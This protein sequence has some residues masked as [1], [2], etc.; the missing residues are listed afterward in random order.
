LI[1]PREVWVVVGASLAL[2]L[3]AAVMLN[4]LC[5]K[6]YPLAVAIIW[7]Y[8]Y[9]KRFTWLSHLLLGS[10]LAIAP[11]GAYVAVTASLEIEAL[12]L[13]LAVI[14]WVAGF[15]IIYATQ[16]V[17]FDRRYNLC[18]IPARFGIARALKIS[19]LFHGITLLFLLLLYFFS[20][21][22]ELYLIGI[23]VMAALLA[24]EHA[25]VKPGNLKKVGVAFFNINVLFSLTLFASI[26]LDIFI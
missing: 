21:L 22:G 5:V 1:S 12:L 16:D 24:Y 7:G 23:T 15:D 3:L 18:S 14:F 13:A 17:E 20:P 8:P 4:P 9:A 2:L 11:L 6:L 25:I 10:A 26:A 19:S